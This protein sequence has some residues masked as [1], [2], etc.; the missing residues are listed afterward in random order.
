MA[1]L[2]RRLL[3]LA[4]LLV[5]AVLLAVLGG[6]S[7]FGIHHGYD[8]WGKLAMSA[9]WL[10][11]S[12][13]FVL[14]AVLLMI[15]LRR[16]QAYFAVAAVVSAA[17]CVLYWW[18]WF[19]E[20]EPNA[21]SSGLLASAAWAGAAVCSFMGWSRLLLFRMQRSGAGAEAEPAGVLHELSGVEDERDRP[22]A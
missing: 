5:V 14:G 4:V 20:E 9:G 22:A 6:I 10:L 8:V 16:W 15:G 21:V 12:A 18:M 13:L 19:S 1:W 17:A 2:E 7:L 11:L 3:A